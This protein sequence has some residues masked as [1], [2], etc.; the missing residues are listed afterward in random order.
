MQIK[1]SEV[2]E[3]EWD[4][5]L[6]EQFKTRNLK[7]LLIKKL[8][9]A[10]KNARESKAD[11]NYFYYL[12]YLEQMEIQLLDYEVLTSKNKSDFSELNKNLYLFYVNSLFS[13]NY[14]K[15]LNRRYVNYNQQ[16]EP[17][18]ENILSE[19]KK[20][21]DRHFYSDMTYLCFLIISQ[22][23]NRENYYKLKELFFENYSKLADRTKYT[24]SSIL[25]N[26]FYDVVNEKDNINAERFIYLKLNVEEKFYKTVG[27]GW[28]DRYLFM[29][30]V[31]AGC[32][33]EKF[34]WVEDFIKSNSSELLE[35]IREQYV[36]FAYVTLYI[37]KRNFEKALQHLS[38]CRKVEKRDK[39]TVKYFEF[40]IYYEL[41]YH[42][43]MKYLTDTANHFLSKD[44]VF[45][46]E[47][48]ELF[49]NFVYAINQ[50]MEYKMSESKNKSSLEKIKKF[51]KNNNVQSKNWFEGRVRKF[52][53]ENSK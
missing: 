39:I 42:E 18:L 45:S 28:L 41:G 33:L 14:V 17:F 50:L 12:F 11:N 34:D 23:G 22:K 5:N 1:N 26:F 53:I 29:N 47:F 46:P 40:M 43:E 4:I 13:N 25:L 7:S 49:R 16:T 44:K 3:R 20:Y 32:S 8:K 19:Y 37:K 36:N 27:H 9:E 38:K 48:K 21:P 52:E 35:N 15:L 2:K 51:L 10:K 24:I 6:L 30:T 31:M